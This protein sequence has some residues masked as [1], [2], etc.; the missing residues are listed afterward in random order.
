MKIIVST[1]LQ[2]FRV[3]CEGDLKNLEL[4]TDVSIR[5]KNGYLIKL[6]PK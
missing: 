5:P 1:I 6:L 4:I 3:Y 2:K